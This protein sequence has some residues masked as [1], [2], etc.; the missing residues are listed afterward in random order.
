LQD[1]EPADFLGKTP[2]E[3]AATDAARQNPD[4]LAAKYAAKGGKNHVWIMQH[5][6]SIREEEEFTGV[7]GQ[8][9]FLH[10][11][12]IPVRGGDGKI[13]GTQG[14]LFDITQ[15]KEAEEGYMRLATA[16]E[17]A[18][19]GI[20]ITD[21]AGTI[22]YVN[23]AFEK[24]SGYSRAEVTGQNPRLLKS[25]RQDAA[26]YRHMWDVL[27]HGRVWCGHLVNKK[28][29][30][31][32]FEE[33]ATISPIR[34]AAGKIT[35]HVAVKRDVT[36]EAA[37]EAQL[38]QSQKMEAIGQLAGGIAHDF[39]NLLTAIHANAAQLLET[40]PGPGVAAECSQQ[41]L[42][43]AERAATLTRRL[44]MFS[45]KQILQ[46]VN[47]DLNEVVAQTAK[48]LQR[49]L[50][51]D[52]SLVPE[53]AADLPIIKADAGM[54]EQILLNL[55]V[56]SRDAMPGGG[57]LVIA[58]GTE[59]LDEK[60]A[61][62]QAGARPGLYVQLTITDTGCGIPAEHLPRIFEPFFTTKEAGKGTG[63]GLATV[64]G[65]V[66]QHHGWITVA[67]EAG[68]GTTFRI[69]FPAAAGTKAGKPA[70]PGPAKL[71]RGT[72]VVLLVED[73]LTVRLPVTNMLQRFGYTVIPTESGVEALKLWE[74]NQDS[75]DL[76]LTDIVMPDGLTGYEL[77]RRLQADKPQ[78]K[79]IFTSGYSADLGGRHS[80]LVE[81]VNFLQKPYAPQDLAEILRT[82]LDSSAAHKQ[83]RF[84][85]NRII[86]T[87]SK[88]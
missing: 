14:M 59:L 18:A 31:T 67:S 80:L 41:I 69:C 8:K 38:R 45:R 5:G 61:A 48:M 40:P 23:P 58:T 29:D 12:S 57:K 36:R 25:G 7:N 65:I 30:G 60:L 66:R 76:L 1:L 3:V 22:L 20:L 88:P 10:M 26:F 34:N 55:A 74:L 33:E 51:E 42:E 43:A 52:V 87:P 28:K 19:E 81:G 53:T 39:N 54:I 4:G 85:F 2:G 63:L 83:R 70:A 32:L 50:G 49:I 73:E 44:L 82:S 35:N 13:M 56:N 15:R 37:L 75:I 47:L 64:Y 9:Q 17:Q 16:V 84:G 79:V 27:R 6:K 86:P 68:R 62:R 11:V 72:E 77:A 78:L 21:A 71:P 46:P 24:T